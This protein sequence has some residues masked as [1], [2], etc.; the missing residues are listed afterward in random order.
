MFI[1]PEI[2]RWCSRDMQCQFGEEPHEHRKVLFT[3]F[4]KNKLL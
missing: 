4:P 3:C 1:L 2:L